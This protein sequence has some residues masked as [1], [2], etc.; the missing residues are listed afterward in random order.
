MTVKQLK[1][2]IRHLSTQERILFV[3]YILDTVAEDTHGEDEKLSE[4]WKEEL[5]KRSKAYSSGEAKTNSWE[6]IKER[7]IRKHS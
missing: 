6:D 2:A 7:L 5:D 1:E 3:Q 4:K